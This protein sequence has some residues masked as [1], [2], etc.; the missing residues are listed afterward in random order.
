MSN[1]PSHPAPDEPP[2]FDIEA[3]RARYRKLMRSWPM[4]TM[5]LLLALVILFAWAWGIA[6]AIG[7]DVEN[8]PGH[9][10]TVPTESCIACHT[11]AASAENAPP[12]NH[13][14][15]PTCGFCH[16]QGLPQTGQ[17]YGG[18]A[19]EGRPQQIESYALH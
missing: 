11:T 17:G 9:D 16:L 19:I 8:L 1:Q 4:R 5:Y 18:W 2:Q 14:A 10:I 15:A 7:P 6:A 12:M 3:A 13:P